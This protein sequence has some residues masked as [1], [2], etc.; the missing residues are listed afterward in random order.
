M[1]PHLL[2]ILNLHFQF[3]KGFSLTT[4]HSKKNSK[5]QIWLITTAQCLSHHQ[6][7]IEQIR[8]GESQPACPFRRWVWANV[9]DR[10]L[11]PAMCYRYTTKFRFVLTIRPVAVRLM[12]RILPSNGRGMVDQRIRSRL[13]DAIDP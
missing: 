3:C 5:P 2:L 4:G 10:I 8:A 9:I 1:L 13:V 7:T 12:L 6:V 11:E